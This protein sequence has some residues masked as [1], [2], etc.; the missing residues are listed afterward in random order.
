[1]PLAPESFPVLFV[2]RLS[3]SS[4]HFTTKT[5]PDM[6]ASCLLPSQRGLFVLVDVNI[7]DALSSSAVRKYI[8]EGGEG[9]GEG[10]EYEEL[11]KKGWLNRDVAESLKKW[12]WKP[13]VIQS[14]L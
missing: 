3:A 6:P 1:M 4:L 7:D 11:V 12:G 8:G 2:P 13:T 14:R 5:D 10:S 9:E